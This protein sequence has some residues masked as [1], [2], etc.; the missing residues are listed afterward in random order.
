M[1]PR[2]KPTQTQSPQMAQEQSAQSRI[3]EFAH[4]LRTECSMADN[5]VQAYTRDIHQFYEWMQSRRIS[6]L[7]TLDLKTLSVFMQSLHDRQLSASSIARKLVALKT[8]FRFFVLEGQLTESV[9]ELLNSPKLWQYLPKV[10]SP[11]KVDAL[12]SA[13]TKHDGYPLRDRALLCLM[14]ATGCRASEVA[15]LTLSQISLEE[16]TCRCIGKGNKERIVSLN[17]VAVLAIE[18]YLEH[19]RPLLVN[20]SQENALFVS[21]TGRGLTRLTI[22]R[23]VKRYAGRVGCS[24]EVSPHTLRHSFAT[25]MLAGGAEIRALQEMLGHANIRTTQIY[26]HVEHSRLKSIHRACH[27]RG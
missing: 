10:L 8:L 21:R 11:E 1:P 22:W 26:T 4:F 13:P 18:T 19:E 7:R 27:P 24:G 17:P 5:S 3:E 2:F 20:R 12:L 25:H 23:L 15:S 9:A 6:D 16:K 14:Y